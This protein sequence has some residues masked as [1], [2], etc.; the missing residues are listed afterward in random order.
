MQD[1]DH[2]PAQET[3]TLGWS[4]FEAIPDCVHLIDAHGAIVAMNRNGMCAFDI[5][6]PDA[7]HGSAWRALWPDA[8]RAAIDIALAQA[9]AGATGKA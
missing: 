2:V 5:D 7:L 8:S 9:R 6:N 3:I 4:L 1:S